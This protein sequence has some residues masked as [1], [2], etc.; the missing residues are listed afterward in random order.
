M[1]GIAGAITKEPISI[2]LIKNVISK[3][4]KRGPDNQEYIYQRLRNG[5]HLYLLFSRLAILDLSN[6]SMQPISTTD[7]NLLV[8]NGEIYNYKYLKRKLEA[9]GIAF[10]SEGDAEVLCQLIENFGISSLS[11]VDGMFALAYFDARRESLF[12]ARDFFGEKPLLTFQTNSGLFFG[13][14]NSFIFEFSGVSPKIN[15]DK[16]R[17]FLHFGYKTLFV[18]NKTF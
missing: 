16:C 4:C 3:M 17:D 7:G 5:N 18:D 9:K 13:S 10:K 1:C 15:L 12:L 14:Q 2:N 6:N 8:F 11:Q